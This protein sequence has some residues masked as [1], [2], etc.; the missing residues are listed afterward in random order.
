MP[1]SEQHQLLLQ[2]EVD[3]HLTDD[4]RR[5]AAQLLAE[6]TLGAE[7]AAY[8]AGLRA[9]R[10]MVQKHAQVK[11]SPLLASRV[12]AALEDNFDDVSRPVQNQA[13]ARVHKLPV[14]RFSTMLMAAAAALLVCVGLIFGPGLWQGSPSP[15]TVAGDVNAD[16]AA[17][18]DSTKAA[19]PE[20]ARE[21]D[22]SIR[23]PAQ[24][25]PAPETLPDPE[26]RRVNDTAPI[27]NSVG[28]GGTG[29]GGHDKGGKLTPHNPLNPPEGQDEKYGRGT[30]GGLN[31]RDPAKGVATGPGAS[32][33]LARDASGMYVLRLDRG[34]D[35]T[36]QLG[37][38]ANRERAVSNVQLSTDILSVAALHGEARL[39]DAVEDS[40][41]ADSTRKLAEGV[42]DFTQS[43]TVEVL[44]REDDLVGLLSALA[45]LGESQDYGALHVPD[46]LQA[47][48][49]DETK[50]VETMLGLASQGAT[51]DEAGH[52]RLAQFLPRATHLDALRRLAGKGRLNMDLVP[53]PTLRERL[54]REIEGDGNHKEVNGSPNIPAGPETET[55][56]PRKLRL[57]IQLQ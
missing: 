43:S 29:Q 19:A 5:A 25:M 12:L 42:R 2:G 14:V 23:P 1:L 32:G 48:S 35:S 13:G 21:Q 50:A 55:T 34:R 46:D 57:L 10:A 47:A 24:P 31:R 9:L 49:R 41:A 7:A 11:A 8:V 39:L 44:V 28:G 53:E 4:D 37:F 52:S 27:G 26:D 6:P 30:S 33:E 17:G 45:R 56:R 40:G 18:T 38:E 3:G 54:K 51:P 22:A 36:F 16:G 15:T 20:D